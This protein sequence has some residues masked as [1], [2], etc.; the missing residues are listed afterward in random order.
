MNPNILKTICRGIITK[1]DH[2]RAAIL[3]AEVAAIRVQLR[4]YQLHVINDQVEEQRAA[5]VKSPTAANLTALEEAALRLHNV[6][7]VYRHLSLM[8]SNA[9][10]A[11]LRE[12]VAPWAI[13]ILERIVPV[14]REYCARLVETER[15]HGKQLI[16]SPTN[17]SDVIRA[18][19]EIVP[20]LEALLRT[21]PNQCLDPCDFWGLIHHDPAT[22]EAKPKG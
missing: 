21:L 8:I 10:A 1:E 5:Y 19:E 18:A 4:G 7:E 14:A 22:L 2:A 11:V 9:E 15:Q 20:N 3:Q 13:S 17:A 12:R 6:R 16:G